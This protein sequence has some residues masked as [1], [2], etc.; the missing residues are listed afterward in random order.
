MRKLILAD[1]SEYELDWC[2]GDALFYANIVTTDAFP[3]LA[4]VFYNPNKT[5]KMEAEY[6]PENKRVYEGYTELV[7]IQIGSWRSGTTLITLKKP[8]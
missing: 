3:D 5:I 7:S 6:G 2:H 4:T 8:G 1:G